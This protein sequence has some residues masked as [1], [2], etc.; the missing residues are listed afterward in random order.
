MKLTKARSYYDR[1]LDAVRNYGY[2]AVSKGDLTMLA[3]KLGLVSI[4]GAAI[5]ALLLALYNIH[6]I[7]MAADRRH[8][9]NIQRSIAR[10]NR[11]RRQIERERI[12]AIIR[13]MEAYNC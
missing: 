9:E 11:T 6:Q 8:D 1:Y 4:V 7:N 2:R 12:D 13:E 5:G 10:I 3:L